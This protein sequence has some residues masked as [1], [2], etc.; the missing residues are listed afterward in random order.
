MNNFGL[1]HIYCGDGKGKTTAA[2]GLAMRACSVG[3]KVLIVQFLKNGKSP[4]VVS[5]KEKFGIQ[6]LAYEEIAG[7]SNFFD[8]NQHEECLKV[9]NEN[10]KT[11]ISMKNDFDLIVFDEII[12]TINSK[13]VDESLL[14]NFLENKPKNLEIVMTGRDPSE[15]LMG[16]ADY[17]SEVKK[18]K[19]PFDQ[20]IHAR[21]GIE[22]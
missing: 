11:A 1:V 21:V 17:I 12:A 8:E 14:I 4:E 10:L 13:L 22:K 18:I 15:E 2:M 20:G 19:H 5:L 7:F 9:H 3:A 6:V 16:F